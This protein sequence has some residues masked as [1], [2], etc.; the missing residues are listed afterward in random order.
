MPSFG[1]QKHAYVHRQT[2]THTYEEVPNGIE[3]DAIFK[4]NLRPFCAFSAESTV[5]SSMEENEVYAS[6]S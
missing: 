4:E 2:A 1:L 6:R 5:S 3:S